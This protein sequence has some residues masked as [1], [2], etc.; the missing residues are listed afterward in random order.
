MCI[1]PM[2]KAVYYFLRHKNVSYRDKIKLCLYFTEIKEVFRI[3]NEDIALKRLKRL[4]DNF[5][6][7]LV[8][9]QKW[10]VKKI[11]PDFGLLLHESWICP[12]NDQ[13]RRELSSTDR[14]QTR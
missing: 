8:V 4:L 14:F 5:D 11:L 3:Y 9:L 7:I 1:K 6:D 13:S 2:T 10:I 12:Q